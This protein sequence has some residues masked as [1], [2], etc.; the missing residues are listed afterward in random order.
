MRAVSG[1][2][3]FQIPRTSY[4]L[5]IPRTWIA[6]LTIHETLIKWCLDP[7][8]SQKLLKWLNIQHMFVARAPGIKMMSEIVT[9]ILRFSWIS[10][11][12]RRAR[13]QI[14]CCQVYMRFLWEHIYYRRTGHMLNH[15]A[16]SNPTWKSWEDNK[17]PVS[18]VI[19]TSVGIYTCILLFLLHLKK[20]FHDA[21]SHGVCP[22]PLKILQ[23]ENM[24]CRFSNID[25][26]S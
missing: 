13:N 15:S 6:S 18:C 11:C 20:T 23:K 16:S 9:E 10:A 22:A 17:C 19:K 5:A 3:R 12:V 8:M 25:H 2:K 4:H 1:R 21:R 26:R 14:S 24:S 7:S